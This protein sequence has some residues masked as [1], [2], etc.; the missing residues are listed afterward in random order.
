LPLDTRG[1]LVTPLL[2]WV[3]GWHGLRTGP[4]HLAEQKTEIEAL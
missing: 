3:S 1:E 2:T 4:G